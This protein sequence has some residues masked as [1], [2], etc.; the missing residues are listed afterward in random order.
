MATVF[1]R[2]GRKSWII[3]FFDFDGRRVERSSRTT[4]KRKAQRLADHYQSEAMLRREGV[5]DPAAEDAART[6]RQAIAEWV[7]RFESKLRAEKRTE[8]HICDTLNAIRN[9][10]E[11]QG[12]KTVGDIQPVRVN[13]YAES[14]FKLGRS[15]RTVHAHLTALKSFT[16]WM[17]D[18]GKL[19]IDPLRSVKKPNPKSDR[20]RVRRMLQVEEYRWLRSVTIGDEERFGMSGD[21]RD[22]LYATAI[23]TGLRSA[24][25]RAITPGRLRFESTTRPYIL[26]EARVAKNRK[27]AHQ[28]IKPVQIGRAHV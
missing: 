23:Q 18:Q 19:G 14:L 3:Q 15:A 28:Y 22:L 27:Q 25:L 11:K 9:F 13:A 4:D 2:K 5:V 8:G 6:A 16:R 24:E 20:K 1:K 7:E 12:A 17:T 21:E 26:A 10:I